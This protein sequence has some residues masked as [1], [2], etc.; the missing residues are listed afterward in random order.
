MKKSR[1]NSQKFIA[2]QATP[3]F[4]RA[5][6]TQHDLSGNIQTLQERVRKLQRM[7]GVDTP[8]LH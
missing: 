2:S 3:R 7:P 4:T 1:K 8:T 6:V 5:Q